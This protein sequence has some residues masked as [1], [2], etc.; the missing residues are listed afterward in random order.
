M[1]S[2][3]SL[4]PSQF[5]ASL[6]GLAPPA[7]PASCA[8]LSQAC[9]SGEQLFLHG[10]DAAAELR[11]AS[12]V[13]GSAPNLYDVKASGGFQDSHNMVQIAS[14]HQPYEYVPLAVAAR[15]ARGSSLNN[16]S[17]FLAPG[18][19]PAAPAPS[20]Y[21]N[22]SIALAFVTTWSNAWQETYHRATIQVFEQWCR[23]A[24]EDLVVIPAAFGNTDASATVDDADLW[25][26]PFSA[27][28]VLSMSLVPKPEPL[29]QALFGN[30]RCDPASCFAL[31]LEQSA[32][33]FRA[34]G[35]RCF[36]RAKLCQFAYTP[37]S[38]RPWSAMQAILAHHTTPPDARHLTPNLLAHPATHTLHVTFVR[39][40]TRRRLSNLDELLA[41]C[42]RWSPAE[43]TAARLRVACVAVSFRAGLVASA[44]AIR[45]T[46]VL[47]GPHGA[48]MTNAL[49]M[50]A[51]ASVLEV[52]PVHTRGCPCDKFRQVFGMEPRTLYHYTAQ[53]RNASYATSTTRPLAG[54]YNSDLY[55]PPAVLEAA[56][57]HVVDVGG[58]PAR[59][60]FRTFEY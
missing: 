8:S 40:D 25:L 47:V 45:R 44:P 48:D 24:P 15:T 53:S 16:R 43:G 39:R 58:D 14:P 52:I 36:E 37:R 22:S 23:A 51:G 55:L 18:V 50:H 1:H 9:F 29:Q 5:R 59:Y 34:V 28:P 33:Y 10:P 54:T 20:E 49:G 56:L 46:D 60:R 35:R 30:K 13:L 31:Y 27:Q 26:R 2:H 6:C 21:A 3:Q 17:R 57:Q 38:G 11:A 32:A 42:E 7:R 41:A 4:T 19:K 12:R